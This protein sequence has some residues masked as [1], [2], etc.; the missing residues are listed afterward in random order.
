M[1]DAAALSL[2]TV[3][4]AV[5]HL[6]A[7]LA[8]AGVPDPKQE[9]RDLLAS[10]LDVAR[11]WPS[12]NRDAELDGD[13]WVLACRAAAKRARGAPFAYAVGRAAFRHL[14]LDVDERVLIPR[15]ETEVLVDLVLAAGGSGGVAVDVGTGSGAIALALAS[16]GRFDRVVATDV[17]REALAVAGGNARLL[18]PALTARI[19]LRHGSLLAPVRGLRARVV[20][21]NP[22]YVAHH[23]AAALPASVRDWEPPL[24]LFGGADGMAAIA[25]IVRDAPGVLEPGGLLALEVDARRASLAAELAMADGRYRDVGVRLDLAGRERFVL[26]TRVD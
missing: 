13:V 16:E 6:A 11:F 10:L 4:A 24:A 2:I 23:E 15:Q 19:E 7:L 3:G 5:N 1:A 18:A 17:S 12:M 8:A 21:S 20:V 22:P 14:T 26:A 9:G 25:A